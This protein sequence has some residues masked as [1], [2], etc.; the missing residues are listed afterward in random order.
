ML[1]ARY[2]DRHGRELRRDEALDDGVLKDGVTMRTPMQA[3]DGFSD[4]PFA[5][6]K[7]GFRT[8]STGTPLADMLARDAKRDAYLDYENY[9]TSAY[10]PARADAAEQS[11][12]EDD[13]EVA[14]PQC[15]GN[16]QRTVAQRMADHEANMNKV[17]ADYAARQ[18]GA[19]KERT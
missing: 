1:Q 16:D 3:R 2:F 11:T 4:D 8:A 17:Y 14:C 9:I 6:N 12:E 13:D 7:P 10:R 18:S 19:W 5:L 15:A